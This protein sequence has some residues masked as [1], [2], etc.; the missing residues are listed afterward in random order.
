MFA[1][2]RMTKLDG[3]PGYIACEWAK[4]VLQPFFEPFPQWSP[5]VALTR[6]Q[7]HACADGAGDFDGENSGHDFY[8]VSCP[9]PAHRLSFLLLTPCSDSGAKLPTA[10]VRTD[11]LGASVLVLRCNLNA[12]RNAQ[13]VRPL[14][15]A[16]ATL[17]ASL[18]AA[19]LLG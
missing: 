2:L 1:L 13:R 19:L 18:K 9:L 17:T 12:Q 15:R 3:S 14:S 6:A 5:S 11:D 8:G 16:C 7:I 4:V 10:S